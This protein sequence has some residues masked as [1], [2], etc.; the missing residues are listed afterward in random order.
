[1]QPFVCSSI[2]FNSRNSRGQLLSQYG[3]VVGTQFCSLYLGIQGI[4]LDSIFLFL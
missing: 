1:M 3:T 4:I 2:A